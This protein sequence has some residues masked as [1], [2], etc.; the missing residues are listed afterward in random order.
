M[1]LPQGWALKSLGELGECIIG[2]TYRPENV[3]TDNGTLVG[4][5]SN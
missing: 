1:Q 3:V 2:L 4:D 5:A